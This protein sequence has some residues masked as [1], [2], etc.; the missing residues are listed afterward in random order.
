MRLTICAAALLLAALAAGKLAADFGHPEASRHF[1][2]LT[3]CLMAA[4]IALA[5]D[6]RRSR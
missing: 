5:W 3:A 4:V 2:T 1:S 6:R